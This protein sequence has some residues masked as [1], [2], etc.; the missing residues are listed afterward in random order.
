MGGFIVLS[1][2][3]GSCGINSIF[4]THSFSSGRCHRFTIVSQD[5]NSNPAH[6]D[7][8]WTPWVGDPDP[9]HCAAA[10]PPPPVPCGPDGAEGD[11]DGVVFAAGN[12][13]SSSGW[14]SGPGFSGAARTVQVTIDAKVGFTQSSHG[15]G[16]VI[17]GKVA[18][19]AVLLIWPVCCLGPCCPGRR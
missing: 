15:N 17:G 19:L 18:L 5:P 2:R 6:F 4:T 3:V 7:G 8:V 10:P 14:C 1:S 11:A 9:T 13:C 12:M 16:G